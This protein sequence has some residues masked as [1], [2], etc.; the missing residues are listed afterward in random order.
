[1]VKGVATS[2]ITVAVLMGS[3]VACGSSSEGDAKKWVTDYLAETF[4]PT[5]TLLEIESLTARDFVS[6]CYLDEFEAFSYRN[7]E[8][9]YWQI[10]KSKFIDGSYSGIRNSEADERIITCLTDRTTGAEFLR[11][12][13]A[14][15]SGSL[16][17]EKD[18]RPKEVSWSNFLELVDSGLINQVTYDI[19]TGEIQARDTFGYQVITSGPL[20]LSIEEQK[21]LTQNVYFLT[22]IPHETFQP[23]ESLI[24][25]ESSTRKIIGDYDPFSFP[26]CE[27]SHGS[28]TV[29]ALD[30]S[31]CQWI[32]SGQKVA[33]NREIR[34]DTFDEAIVVISEGFHPRGTIISSSGCSEWVRN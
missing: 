15:L 23:C 4:E 7:G 13:N 22:L 33:S 6:Q 20:G 25:D 11:I 1:M 29:K 30:G 12:D 17:F 24:F 31:N 9:D 32:V 27:V 3:L 19:N 18:T 10:T 14:D 2:I 21:L 16:T 8:D 26:K 34:G 28:Y 5:W